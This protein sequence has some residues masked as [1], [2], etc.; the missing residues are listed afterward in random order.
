[1]APLPDDQRAGQSLWSAQTWRMCRYRKLDAL[2]PCVAHIL[3]FLPSLSYSP[4]LV[5]HAFPCIQPKKGSCLRV[6]SR[7]LDYA[8]A[9]ACIVKCVHFRWHCTVQQL[10][11]TIST[12]SGYPSNSCLNKQNLNLSSG[13]PDF[14]WHTLQSGS[15]TTSPLTLT[16]LHSLPLLSS[17]VFGA[18]F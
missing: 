10:S 11:A 5:S 14:L 16:E 6:A 17:P 12:M 8:Y 2:F 4:I 7:S 3:Y 13:P 9:Y 18:V 1:M 15:P